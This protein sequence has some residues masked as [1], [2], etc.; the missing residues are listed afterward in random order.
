MNGLAGQAPQMGQPSQP[1]APQIDRD[2]IENIKSMV[3]TGKITLEELAQRG[4][5]PEVLQII[6]DELNQESSQAEAGGIMPQGGLA[7]QAP[8]A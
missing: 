1:T 4:L 7:G 6:V 5:P 2:T 8:L 3:R